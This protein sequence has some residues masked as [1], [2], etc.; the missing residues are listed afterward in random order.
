MKTMRIIIDKRSREGVPEMKRMSNLLN[1]MTMNDG[2]NLK[3]C[4]T[5]TPQSED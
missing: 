2:S 4:E 3:L 5:E 1:S